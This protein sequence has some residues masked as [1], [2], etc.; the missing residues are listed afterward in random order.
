MVDIQ[1]RL[2]E[3][4]LK[5]K[6]ILQVHDELN[7]DV[8]KPE[9]DKVKALVKEAMESAVKLKVPLVVDMGVGKNWLEAH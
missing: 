4:G 9:L 3:E 8:F 7:F 1:Q 5:S 6:M 2:K